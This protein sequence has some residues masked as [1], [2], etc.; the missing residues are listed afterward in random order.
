MVVS[1]NKKNILAVET[2][3]DGLILRILYR[4]Y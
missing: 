4:C 3:F 2:K 1:V